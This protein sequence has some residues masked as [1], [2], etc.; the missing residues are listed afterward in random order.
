MLPN[1]DQFR[2]T[3]Y[4]CGDTEYKSFIAP[5]MARCDVCHRKCSAE[6]KKKRN[7]FFIGIELGPQ[8]SELLQNI[9]LYNNRNHKNTSSDDI[10]DICNGTLYQC[11]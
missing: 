9:N 2:H 11:I 7:S 10:S 6:K 8:G 4:Y 5:G 1:T 3:H